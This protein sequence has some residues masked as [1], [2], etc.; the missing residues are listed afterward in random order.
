MTDNWN[1]RLSEYI[2]DEL[3]PGERAQLEAHLASCQE[4]ALTLEDLRE[5]VSRAG[6]L[7][8]RPPIDDLW[9]GIEPHVVSEPRSTVV[10]FQVRAMRRFSFTLPQLV[11]AGLALMVMSGGG[12]WILQ[13]GGRATDAPA[14]VAYAPGIDPV[15]PAALS[16]PRYDEAIAD[17]EQALD[18]GRAD[19]DPGTVKI[20]EA[21]LAAIDKAIDQSR[22]ALASDPANVYLNNHLADA[23]Q[24]KLALLRRATSLVGTKG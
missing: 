2:D 15:V 23:R 8:A 10:P 11:A 4:C 9:P 20:L 7:P 24:R 5:V 21:N 14:V 16:D 1:D 3:T 13:H 17:L 19:L 22:Q 18:A 12:V 6:T